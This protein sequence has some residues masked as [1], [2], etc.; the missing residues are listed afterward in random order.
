MGNPNKSL[1]E[2]DIW[3]AIQAHEIGK[4]NSAFGFKDRLASENNWSIEFAEDAIQEY[5]RFM[6]LLCRSGHPVTPSVEVDQVW[7]LH[8]L[9]TKDY[10]EIFADKLSLTPHHGPTRGGKAEASK[11]HEWYELTLSSYKRIFCETPPESFWPPSSERFREN[12]NY[13]FIDISQ[14]LVV[15]RKKAVSFCLLLVLALLVV[16]FY[17]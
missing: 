15:P 4:S 2:D 6:F 7:H 3:V 8:L 12:Q 17:K 16:L 10:W 1:N 5:K 13:K 9:Y 14:M 11:F